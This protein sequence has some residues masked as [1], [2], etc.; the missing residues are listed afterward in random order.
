MTLN[1]YKSMQY[2]KAFIFTDIDSLYER[3]L[4][5]YDYLSKVVFSLEDLEILK[6]YILDND[7]TH[8]INCFIRKNI[9]DLLDYLLENIVFD[10]K[11]DKFIYKSKCFEIKNILSKTINYDDDKFI[12]DEFKKRT[13]NIY[14]NYDICI[15]NPMYINQYR[16]LIITSLIYDNYYLNILVDD[17][18]FDKNRED[19]YNTFFLWSLNNFIKEYPSIL[20]DK[21]IRKRIK[22]ILLIITSKEYKKETNDVIILKSASLKILEKMK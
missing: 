3:F 8:I 19:Y 2:V 5:Q 17:N 7:N 13:N 12:I 14:E 22:Y 1:K 4:C 9:S 20:L 11:K 6:N 10:S 16:D 18:E 21:K 15:E